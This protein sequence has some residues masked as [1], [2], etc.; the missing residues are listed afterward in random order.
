MDV[1]LKRVK[2]K[3]TIYKYSSDWIF[4][5]ESRQHWDFYWHQQKIME[6]ILC[7]GNHENIIE[8]GVGS[9]FTTNYCRSKGFKVTTL[10]IDSG[11]NPDILAN[12][13]CYEFDQKYDYLMAFEVL[14][15][16]PFEE[17]KKIINR[18]P[19]FVKKYAFISLPRNERCLFSLKIKIPKVKEMKLEWKIKARKIT[20]ETHFWELDYKHYKTKK[21][22]KFFINAGLKIKRKILCKYITFYA[23]EIL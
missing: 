4:S 2:Y 23:L 15:H 12:A 22:E 8:I 21:I 9:G 18:I 1:D 20:T 7:A 11:K 6:G 16:M 10:D 13:V 3:N 17:F 19:H 5:L 14:E